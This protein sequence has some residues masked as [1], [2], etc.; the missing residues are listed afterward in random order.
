[1]GHP[2]ASTEAMI[3]RCRQSARYSTNHTERVRILAAFSQCQWAQ[4]SV[5]PESGYLDPQSLYG[6][7]D[8]LRASRQVL[9][10]M[11]Q[12]VIADVTD[13]SSIPKQLEATVPHLI[14]TAPV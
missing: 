14:M 4:H 1:M 11:A 10:R 3:S 2:S 7:A 5:G 9:A 13:P 12:F 6:A 8:K